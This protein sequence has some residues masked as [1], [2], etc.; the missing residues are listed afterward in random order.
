LAFAHPPTVDVNTF[1]INA[2]TPVLNF[3][4]AEN[5]ASIGWNGAQYLGISASFATSSTTP[6]TASIYKPTG[7]L[8]ELSSSGYILYFDIDVAYEGRT[9]PLNPLPVP[10]V[11]W[12][13]NA[14]FYINL[15]KSTNSGTTWVTLANT[16]AQLQTTRIYNNNRRLTYAERSATTSSLYRVQ[17]SIPQN[18]EYYFS[19]LEGG[20]EILPN[21]SF[22]INQYPVTNYGNVTLFWDTGSG[23]NKNLL[24]AK[25][26]LGTFTVAGGGTVGLNDVWGSRQQ[27]INRSGFES[28]VLDFEPQE[29]DE[30]RFEGTENQSYVITQVSQSMRMGYNALTLVLDK[31]ITPNVNTDYFLLRRY[32]DDPSNIII[33]VDK[34]SGGTSGGVLKPEF[35]TTQ[36][37]KQARDAISSLLP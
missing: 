31:D 2:S 11:S 13:P 36:T 34:P 16:S 9:L 19:T 27:N 20:L 7:S 10:P 14:A 17:I 3:L 25:R 15:Q 8:G 4:L 21:S 23:N 30:I 26:G 1:S 35:V 24:F 12:N 37:E 29:Q 5:T 28:I 6:L 18:S 22:Q 33:D 32:V